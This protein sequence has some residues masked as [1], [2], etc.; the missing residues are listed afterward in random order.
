M[1]PNKRSA[2]GAVVG[3]ATGMVDGIPVKA[4]KSANSST[5]SFLLELFGAVLLEGTAAPKA[6]VKSPNSWFSSA[7]GLKSSKSSMTLL[8]EVVVVVVVLLFSTE[9][10]SSEC[11]LRCVGEFMP[12]SL[13]NWEAA[14]KSIRLE[15]DCFVL[16]C[17][18]T[19]FA[20]KFRLIAFLSIVGPLLVPALTI[21][22]TGGDARL[23]DLDLSLS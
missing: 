16:F 8:L 11:V 12:R 7:R 6:V 23:G 20:F 5:S 9:N 13:P 14:P 22:D 21:F 4:E 19:V 10:K 15:P 2:L 1:S 18:F 3:A 17:D